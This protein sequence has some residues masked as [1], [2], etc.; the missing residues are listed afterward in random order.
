[1]ETEETLP[2]PPPP[3]THTQKRIV[4]GVVVLCCVALFVVSYI[5]HLYSAHYP[6]WVEQFVNAHVYTC[7]CTC[8]CTHTVHAS[9]IVLVCKTMHTCP[10]STLSRCMNICVLKL[11]T[12]RVLKQAETA[13]LVVPS[14]SSLPH[15]FCVLC[16][17]L[18]CRK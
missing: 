7:T 13:E 1:M 2:P 8:T 17:P 10:C 16:N 18:P 6:S 12:T 4:L 11:H 3:H 5:V 15:T 9:C 14:L